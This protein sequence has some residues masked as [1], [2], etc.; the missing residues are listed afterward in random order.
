MSCNQV[1]VKYVGETLIMFCDMAN[2]LGYND[3]IG[4]TL[5][6]VTSADI[7][8]VITDP[9]KLAIDTT[10]LNELGV[11]KVIAANKGVY[12]TVAAGTAGTIHDAFT[13]VIVVT[14]VTTSGET[15]TEPLR[16]KVLDV[17]L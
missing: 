17:A 14:V 8:L 9:G 13:A 5:P 6:V 16:I 12:F 10:V 7:A 3:T 4:A 2:T 11:E 1:R 15:V